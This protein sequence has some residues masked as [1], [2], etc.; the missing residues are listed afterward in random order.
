MKPVTVRGSDKQSLGVKE[1][2]GF[3]YLTYVQGNFGGGEFVKVF[4]ENDTWM[5]ES[6]EG[7]PG[8]GVQATA[9]CV[10]FSTEGSK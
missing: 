10:E 1:N 8:L 9:Q 7:R 2:E 5:V 6:H 4:V 3:C